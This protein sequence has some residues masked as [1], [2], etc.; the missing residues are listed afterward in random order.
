MSKSITLVGAVG[1]LEEI[2]ARMNGEISIDE[3][4]KLY[5]EAVKLIDFANGKLETARLKV[6]KLTA[7]KEAGD[8]PV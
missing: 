6:E 2:L 8:E 7:P 3:S 5:G 1:R 4:I